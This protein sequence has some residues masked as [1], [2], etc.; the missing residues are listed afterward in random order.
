[1]LNS[2]HFMVLLHFMQFDYN[3]CCSI[4]EIEHGYVTVLRKKHDCTGALCNSM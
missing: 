2:N 1:M 4:T 3:Y